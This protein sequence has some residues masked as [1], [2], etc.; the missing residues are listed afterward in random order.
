MYVI[1][2]CKRF[3]LVQ[4][5]CVRCPWALQRERSVRFFWD[6]FSFLPFFLLSGSHTFLPD[7]FVLGFWKIFGEI[8]F[9]QTPLQTCALKKCQLGAKRRVKRSQTRQ[10]R[11]PSVPA[12]VLNNH[13]LLFLIFIKKL[14][15]SQMLN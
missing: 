4:A 6:Y 2:V 3:I 5:K 9:L 13:W 7:G 14:D 12:I 10:R 8:L 11:P 1:N 15:Q